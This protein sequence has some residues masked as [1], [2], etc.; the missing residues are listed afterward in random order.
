MVGSNLDLQNLYSL[1][2]TTQNTIK[3]F[4]CHTTN[5]FPDSRKCDHS[6]SNQKQL[7]C[8]QAEAYLEAFK[9]TGGV[10]CREIIE[11]FL[12]CEAKEELL[13][14]LKKIFSPYCSLITDPSMPLGECLHYDCAATINSESCPFAE[15]HKIMIDWEGIKDEIPSIIQLLAESGLEYHV[16]EAEDLGEVIKYYGNIQ[17]LVATWVK[18]YN[19]QNYKWP[20][21]PWL[22]PVLNSQEVTSEMLDSISKVPHS[23]LKRWFEFMLPKAANN[24]IIIDQL[25]KHPITTK[26]LCDIILDDRFYNNNDIYNHL[27]IYSGIPIN[28]LLKSTIKLKKK[29]PG[30]ILRFLLV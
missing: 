28:H 5:L 12:F 10:N 11:E 16:R 13:Y 24:L 14:R 15:Q 7:E 3:M 9:Q 2:I 19:I 1:T 23:T 27:I 18:Y 26:E 29:T 21:E 22:H 20:V 17:T 4:K 6:C 25:L 8:S 30:K